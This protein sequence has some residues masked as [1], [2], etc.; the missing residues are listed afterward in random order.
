MSVR[1]II[2][3]RP[4][5]LLHFVWLGK[6]LAKVFFHLPER[7]FKSFHNILVTS[8]ELFRNGMWKKKQRW[9]YIICK[10]RLLRKSAIFL[11]NRILIFWL[12]F[13]ILEKLLHCCRRWC[14]HFAPI[15]FSWNQLF[16]IKCSTLHLKYHFAY[17]GKVLFFC[18]LC[19]Y[20]LWVLFQLP[21]FHC[22]IYVYRWC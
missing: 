3:R 9:N 14:F 22:I 6:L 21:L 19:F 12:S 7:S 16:R 11:C 5:H 4:L 15:G 18:W 10:L 2:S 13:S 17:P 20:W 8:W 1:R